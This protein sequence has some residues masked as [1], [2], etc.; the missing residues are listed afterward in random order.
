MKKLITILACALT[1]S[2]L[3]CAKNKEATF[4]QVDE[5]VLN[6]YEYSESEKDGIV[7]SINEEDFCLVVFKNLGIAPENVKLVQ[8]GKDYIIQIGEVSESEK[9][10]RY[11]FKYTYPEPMDEDATLIVRDGEKEYPFE[12]IFEFE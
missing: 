7:Y 11:V 2:L 12:G 6:H 8:D 1:L 4:E 5:I 10:V 9:P 3:G